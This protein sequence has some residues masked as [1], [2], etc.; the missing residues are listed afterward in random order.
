MILFLCF[1][2][3]KKK[4]CKFNCSLLNSCLLCITGIEASEDT[5]FPSAIMNLSLNFT[6]VLSSQLCFSKEK[7]YLHLTYTTAK[8]CF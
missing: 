8:K 1:K 2:V 7:Q 5:N 6:T 3:R 4:K